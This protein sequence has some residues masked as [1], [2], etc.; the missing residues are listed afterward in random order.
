ML[1]KEIYRWGSD[2]DDQ[3]KLV[4]GKKSAQ[5]FN[6][7]SLLHICGTRSGERRLKDIDRLL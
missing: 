5:I 2:G 3:I 4:L 7:R 6:E 1:L